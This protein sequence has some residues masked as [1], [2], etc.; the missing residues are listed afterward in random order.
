MHVE[1][2]I[3]RQRYLQKSPCLL[4]ISKSKSKQKLRESSDLSAREGHI[5]MGA[6]CAWD[7]AHSSAHSFSFRICSS[8]SGVKLNKFSYLAGQTKKVAN[9]L[10]MLNNVLICSG[11][12]PL[13]MLLSLSQLS[14]VYLT[15]SD[16]LTRPK[17]FISTVR[18]T[19]YMHK[20]HSLAANIPA[21]R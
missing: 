16:Q 1:G 12:L 7:F 2:F 19:G 3:S 10:T 15:A 20:T 14:P 13:I 21:H 5:S 9:S 17:G 11:V 4:I 6:A 18:S 8:S